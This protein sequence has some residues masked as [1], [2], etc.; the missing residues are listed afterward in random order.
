MIHFLYHFDYQVDTSEDAPMAILQD[1]RLFLAADKYLVQPLRKLALK[2]IRSRL[3]TEWNTE[4]FSAAIREIY[5]LFPTQKDMLKPE[6]IKILKRHR[7]L[8][9]NT[10]AIYGALESALRELGEFAADAA[11][12]LAEP[13]LGR[14]RAQAFKCPSCDTT[15]CV[16]IYKASFAA[17]SDVTAISGVFLVRAK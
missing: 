13:M 15:F 12:A 5:T 3:R 9:Q 16:P 1:I 14:Y 2:N 10:D 8:L 4:A 6:I 7:E 11:I 17:P